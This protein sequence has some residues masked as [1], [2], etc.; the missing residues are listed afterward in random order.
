MTTQ[1]EISNGNHAEIAQRCRCD[2]VL[3][4]PGETA[5]PVSLREPRGF[6]ELA[7][8]ATRNAGRYRE[9]RKR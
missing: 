8:P 7:G 9:E 4:A 2:Q 5:E 3:C 1:V 6:S